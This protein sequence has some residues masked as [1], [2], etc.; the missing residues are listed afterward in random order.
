MISR[1]CLIAKDAAFNVEDYIEKSTNL[2]FVAVKQC[3]KELDEIERDIDQLLPAAITEVT[4][5]EARQLLA[6]LK[7]ITDL[8]RIGDLL[9]SAAHGLHQLTSPLGREDASLF[10]EMSRTLQRMLEEVHS[11]F[12]KREVDAAKLVLR[13]DS[14]IDRACHKIFRRHFAVIGTNGTSDSSR[15]LFIA[16]AFERAGDHAKNLGEEIIHLVR[17]QSLRHASRARLKSD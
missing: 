3:E 11:G 8:E 14:E 1:A 5:G 10:I 6:C 2:A 12:V 15:I 16:Q 9:L 4:E 17:G 13:T 7:F